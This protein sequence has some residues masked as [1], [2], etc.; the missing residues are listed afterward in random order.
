MVEEESELVVDEEEEEENQSSKNRAAA[1]L[2]SPLMR[3]LFLLMEVPWVANQLKAPTL[4]SLASSTNFNRVMRGS[5]LLGYL[6]LSSAGFS[7]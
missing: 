6:A 7:R 5:T 3:R 1:P 4:F 2:L